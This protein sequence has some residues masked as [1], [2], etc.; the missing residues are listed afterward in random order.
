MQ[1]EIEESALKKET[2]NLSKE[3][4]EDLQEG[5]ADLRMI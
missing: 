2:D 1:M 4:P 3:R 5:L